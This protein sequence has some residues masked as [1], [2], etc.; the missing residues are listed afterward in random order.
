MKVRSRRFVIVAS[1]A[2]VTVLA[3]NLHA[4]APAKR[5]I[6]T[7]ME[8]AMKGSNSLYKKVSLGKGSAN[9]V[10]ALL[11]LFKSLSVEIP[12]EGEQAKWDQRT[13]RLITAVQAVGEGKPNAISELQLAGNCK[14]CHSEHRGD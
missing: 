1:F 7:V 4:A 14:A 8:E 12:P 11:D 6:E 3:W 10:A 13:A 2:L 9:E 5:S